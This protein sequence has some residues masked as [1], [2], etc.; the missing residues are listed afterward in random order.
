MPNSPDYLSQTL[1]AAGILT[2][3]WFPPSAPTKWVPTDYWRTPVI[4]TLMIDLMTQTNKVDYT[5]TVEAARLK[6]EGS[7]TSCAYY[8]DLTWWGRLFMHAYHYFKSQS[9]NDLAQLYL[10]D[11]KVVCG[12]LSQ[13]WDQF[14]TKEYCGGGVWWMREWWAPEPPYDPTKTFKASNSTL[15]L[16][17]TALALYL[18]LGDQMYL[19]LGQKCWDWLVQW[20]FLDDQGMIWGAL[21]PGKCELDPENVPVLS[22]QGE[23]LAPLWMLYEATNKTSKTEYLDVADKIA[24]GTMAKM[25]WEGTQIMQDQADA[26]WDGQTTDWKEGKSNNTLFKGLFATY[27]AEYTKN[28]SSLRPQQ[29][30]KYAAFLRANADAVW[31]N[32]PGATFGMNWSTLHQNYQ[33]LPPDNKDIPNTVTLNACLQYSGI[34]ALA[35]AALVST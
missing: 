2:D 18:E 32:Y 14:A 27:L 31:A 3:K 5:A 33:P 19:D 24:E 22:L 8:D 34:A 21:V 20:K 25:V 23:G 7:L 35:G 17:E 28:V 9:K 13:G 15:G 12:N 6:G 11:A 30:A 16:M 1:T 10:Y 29:A 26:E 4:C